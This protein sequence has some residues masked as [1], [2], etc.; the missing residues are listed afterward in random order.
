[1]KK[2]FKLLTTCGTEFIVG[3]IRTTID[4][5]FLVRPFDN[6]TDDIWDY[7][8]K[9]FPDTRFDDYPW[10]VDHRFERF[11]YD[12]FGTKY[13]VLNMGSMQENEIDWEYDCVFVNTAGFPSYERWKID[14]IRT[15]SEIDVPKDVHEL[16]E[17]QLRKLREEI[18]IGSCFLSDYNNSMCI[19]RNVLSDYCDDYIEYLE[20]EQ[21]DDTPEVFAYYI[22]EVA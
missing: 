7:L 8:K 16:S 5:N 9:K 14:S 11:E 1:M 19:D 3:G 10:D 2:D 18:C 13:V 22:R 17:Y 4:C 20:E 21:R 6:Y 12:E 15:L